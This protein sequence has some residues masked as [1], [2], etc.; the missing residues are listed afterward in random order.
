MGKRNLTNKPHCFLLTSASTLAAIKA[1]LR[2]NSELL[3]ASLTLR[4]A[5]VVVLD[6]DSYPELRLLRLSMYCPFI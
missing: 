3:E 5:K 2:S 6:G 4:A 1:T